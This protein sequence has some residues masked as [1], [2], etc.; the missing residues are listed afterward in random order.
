MPRSV[1]A[2]V[3]WKSKRLKVPVPPAYKLALLNAKM[4]E[5]KNIALVSNALTC[6]TIQ[7]VLKP[8]EGL[9]P[10]N[11]ARDRELEIELKYWYHVALGSLVCETARSKPSAIPRSPIAAKIQRCL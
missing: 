9:S 11:G 4:L 10:D 5:P 3:S 2:P 7:L 6:T 8:I 1:S